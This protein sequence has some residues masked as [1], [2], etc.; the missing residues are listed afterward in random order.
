[1]EACKLHNSSG[2]SDHED[3][4]R[5]HD[6][7]CKAQMAGLVM[8]ER[9]QRRKQSNRESAR[10]SRMR[11]QKYL[12]DL[13]REVAKLK[14]DNGEILRRVNGAAEQCVKVEAEN[15]VLRRQMEELA[16][17][18]KS[19]NT[20]LLSMEKKTGKATDIADMP[21]PL[22]KPWQL[23]FPSQLV[24]TSARMLRC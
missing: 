17:K 16:E 4:L 13:L 3:D 1:M 20:V 6:Q 22:L 9:K 10:R 14:D 21:D 15:V 24:A 19:L 5:M 23:P 2:T 8:D 11:K 12:E 18:L 7:L